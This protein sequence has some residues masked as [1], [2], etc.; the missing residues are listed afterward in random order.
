MNAAEG[1]RGWSKQKSELIRK[2][3]V[4]TDSDLVFD[5]GGKGEMFRKLQVRLGKTKEELRKI[6]EAL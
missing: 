2:F 4:L 3:A 5:E 6:I 1:N